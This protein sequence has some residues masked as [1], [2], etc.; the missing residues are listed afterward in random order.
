MKATVEANKAIDNVA[1]TNPT[2]D[3]TTNS[4]D[5]AST[6]PTSTDAASTDSMPSAS[7]SDQTGGNHKIT[8]FS[9]IKVYAPF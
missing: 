4:V 5:T 8:G 3:S 6:D 1:Q 2:V 9:N 7:T